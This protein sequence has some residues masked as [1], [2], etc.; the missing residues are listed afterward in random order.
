MP[1]WYL[2]KSLIEHY[3]N[4]LFFRYLRKIGAGLPPHLGHAGLNVVMHTDRAVRPPENLHAR[5]VLI[6][7]RP[8]Y[9]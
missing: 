8:S 9:C 1:I 5:P 6:P 4:L 2:T 3:P 7:D